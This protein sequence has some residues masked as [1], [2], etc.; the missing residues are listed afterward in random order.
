LQPDGKQAIRAVTIQ[1][2]KGLVLLITISSIGIV[3]KS[4]YSHLRSGK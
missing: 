1:L 4:S 2:R 3:E